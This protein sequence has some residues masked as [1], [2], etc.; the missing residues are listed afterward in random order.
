MRIKVVKWASIA[1][2]LGAAGLW[3]RLAPFEVLVRFLVTASALVLM[4]Q[5]FQTR[6][7]SVAAAFGALAVLYNPVAHIF[8]FQ[9]VG[10]AAW[11]W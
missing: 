2:L 7:Y 3:S 5:A 4:F 6:Y 1:R 11:W 9:A 10:N 8:D